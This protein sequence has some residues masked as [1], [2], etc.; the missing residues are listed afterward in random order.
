LVEAR[1]DYVLLHT[2][3]GTFRR[4]QTLGELERSLDP[5]T[6]MRAH[7]SFVVNLNRVERIERYARGSYL[8]VLA[9]DRKVPVSRSAIV[10]LRQRLG[11]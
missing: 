1:D 3:L 4:Q 2:D 10:R 8:A 5:M 6:F 11:G 7:R 9:G